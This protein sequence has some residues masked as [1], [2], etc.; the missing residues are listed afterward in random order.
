MQTL[1]D[2]N[3]FEKE[4]FPPGI[5]P[6]ELLTVRWVRYVLAYQPV[7]TETAHR[8][9]PEEE[10]Q[11]ELGKAVDAFCKRYDYPKFVAQDYGEM[12]IISMSPDELLAWHRAEA[13]N[14]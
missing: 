12:K 8:M 9:T 14:D 13:T 2:R 11:I 1:I 4:M 6:D 10:R 7:V 3:A 5:S